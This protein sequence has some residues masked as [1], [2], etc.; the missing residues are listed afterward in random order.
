[1]GLTLSIKTSHLSL[2]SIDVK[3][4]SIEVATHVKAVFLD[5]NCYKSPL[6]QFS[7]NFMKHFDSLSPTIHKPW[8]SESWEKYDLILKQTGSHFIVRILFG[9]SVRQWTFGRSALQYTSHQ[10]KVKNCF[11]VNGSGLKLDTCVGIGESEYEMYKSITTSNN[12]VIRGGK[13]ETRNKFEVIKTR[14]LLQ[15]LLN[16]GRTLS[17]PIK[18]RYKPV[19]DIIIMKF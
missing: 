5:E 13:D 18:F 11:D 8:L 14:E 3:G 4:S 1:M 9:A 12:L 7:D 16:E 19:W 2:G 15:D 17:E 6:V 10:L